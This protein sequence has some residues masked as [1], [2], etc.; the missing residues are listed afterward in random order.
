MSTQMLTNMPV[1]SSVDSL[2]NTLIDTHLNALIYKS[3]RMMREP[4]PTVMRVTA[5]SAVLV[6]VCAPRRAALVNNPIG[7]VTIGNPIGLSVD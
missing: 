4:N 6:G 5:P 7:M 3:S 2:V 1:N